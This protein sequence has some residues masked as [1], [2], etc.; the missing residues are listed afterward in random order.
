MVHV[1]MIDSLNNQVEIKNTEN[2]QEKNKSI[3]NEKIINNKNTKEK[4]LSNKKY[5]GNNL[6]GIINVERFS[7]YLKLLRVTAFVLRFINNTKK[8]VQKMCG[9]ITSKEIDS[10]EM[11]W[12]K[13]EQN[14]IRLDPQFKNLEK[15]LS[16]FSDDRG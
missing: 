16:L 13:S 10:M 4:I 15:Q 1:N 2:I 3:K 9:V 5:D 8:G 12:I 6:H 11:L 14:F 7:S